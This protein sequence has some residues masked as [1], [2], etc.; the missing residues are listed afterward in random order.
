MM[1]RGTYSELQSSGLDFTTLLKKEE[2]EEG[3]DRERQGATPIPWTVSRF[4]HTLSDNSMSSMSS[5][6]SS[7]YSLSDGAEPLT[8]VGIVETSNYYNL[9]IIGKHGVHQAL[10]ICV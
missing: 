5:L 7:L 6:S 2:E 3:Q 4:P 10:S 9:A 8:V 1:A